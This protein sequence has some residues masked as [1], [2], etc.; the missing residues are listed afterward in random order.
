MEYRNDKERNYAQWLAATHGI[1]IAAALEQ[2][3][4][5]RPRPYEPPAKPIVERWDNIILLRDPRSIPKEAWE[6][7]AERI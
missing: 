2:I 6:R 1:S 4:Q 7:I 5:P 3:R